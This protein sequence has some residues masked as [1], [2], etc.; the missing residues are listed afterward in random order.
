VTAS[1]GTMHL[2]YS[3][4]RA[5]AI[6]QKLD[7]DKPVVHSANALRT[8]L[9]SAITSYGSVE[10]A[11]LHVMKA[12]GFHTSLLRRVLSVHSLLIYEIDLGS[13]RH[14]RGSLARQVFK[15]LYSVLCPFGRHRMWI[16]PHSSD[17]NLISR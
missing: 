11:L 14:F 9:F 5:T 1:Y 13:N 6:K 16:S 7:D 15:V 8:L 17:F 12:H 3:S 4:H 2:A 10:V